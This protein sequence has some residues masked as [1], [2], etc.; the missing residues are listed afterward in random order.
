M[1]LELASPDSAIERFARIASEAREWLLDLVFPPTCGNCGRV[2]YRFCRDCLDE[3]GRVPLASSSREV[4]SL[5]AA[6]A[7]GAHSGLLRHAVQAFKYEGA[8]LLSEALAARLTAALRETN[9]PID[10]I[11][12]VPLFADREEERGYNQSALLSERVAGET[13]LPESANI[14]RRIR[15][16]SQQALLDEPE[17]RANVWDAFEAG[18]NARGLRVLLIDDVVTTGSTLSECARALRAKGASQVFGIAVSHA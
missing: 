4:D 9:W 6:R 5:D 16:T 1:S 12:P 11:V 15:S 7:T 18:E 3:L 17:R 10:V 2:D 14:L 13:G 8:T